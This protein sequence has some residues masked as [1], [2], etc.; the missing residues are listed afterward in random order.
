MQ[1]PILDFTKSKN[2]TS[3]EYTSVAEILKQSREDATREKKQAWIQKEA[4]NQAKV[5]KCQMYGTELGEGRIRQ[6][7]EKE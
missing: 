7:L 5:V 2:L 6:E 3:K 4:L 1:D